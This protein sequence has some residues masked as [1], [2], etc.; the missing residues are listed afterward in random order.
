[1]RFTIAIAVFLAVV[2][3]VTA[4][5]TTDGCAAMSR[6]THDIPYENFVASFG[7]CADADFAEGD[8]C[9]M[10]CASGFKHNE[11]AFC[12]NG[13][14]TFPDSPC[15]ADSSGDSIYQLNTELTCEAGGDYEAQCLGNQ[16]RIALNGYSSRNAAA[17]SWDS[18]YGVVKN[19]NSPGA[20][21]TLS[22]S[23]F[24]DLDFVITLTVTSSIGETLSCD[25]SISI[26]DNEAPELYGIYSE[27]LSVEC[28]DLPSALAGTARDNCDKS[29]EVVFAEDEIVGTSR[30][31][32]NYVI[33]SWTATD[34]C[35]NQASQ[36]QTITVHDTTAPTLHG[37]GDDEFAECEAVPLACDVVAFDNCESDIEVSFNE[38]RQDGDCDSDYTLYR[39]WSAS[40]S[41][42]NSVSASQTVTVSDNTAPELVG[43]P[44]DMIVECT[45]VPAAANVE[46]SDNCGAASL[47]FEEDTTYDRDGVTYYITRTWTATD[48]CGNTAVASHVI[49][50]SDSTPPTITGVGDSVKT[51]PRDVPGVCTVDAIDDCG[52]VTCAYEETT[53][54]GSCL[55][56][57]V[58]TRTWTCTDEA[59]N[60]A[61]ES[62]VIEVFDNNWPTWTGTPP[63]VLTVECSAIPDFEL[64]ATDEEDGH[65]EVHFDFRIKKGDDQNQYTII[66]TWTAEDSCGHQIKF[67]QE[68]NVVDVT[69]PILVGI[70]PS[71][72][73]DCDAIPDCAE[74]YATDNCEETCDKLKVVNEKR[75]ESGTCDNQFDIIRTFSVSD[76]SGNT[77]S[78]EQTIFVTDSEAP[79]WKN[80]PSDI[81]GAE[82][83]Q[84]PKL[85]DPSAKDNCGEATISKSEIEIDG[86]CEHAY[87]LLRY[88]TA[89]DDCGNAAHASQTVEVHD[90]QAPTIQSDIP[91]DV[92]VQCPKIPENKGEFRV[93]DNCDANPQDSFTEEIVDSDPDDCMY[94]I[95]RTWSAWDDC[96]NTVG[97][98]QV[99]TVVDTEP[100]T[101]GRA[102]KSKTVESY[103]GYAETITAFDDCVGEVDVIFSEEEIDSRCDGESTFIRTWTASDGCN[104]D[105][106]TQTIYV[107]DKTPPECEA[108]DDD[109]AD[110]NSIPEAPTVWL[111]DDTGTQY[112]TTLTEKIKNR[113][114]DNTY[115]IIRTYSGEDCAGNR[116][117]CSYTIHVSD[118]EPPTIEAPEDLT[119]ECWSPDCET[120]YGYDDCDG[121]ITARMTQV[122]IDY[123]GKDDYD[124]TIIRTFTA[125]DSCDNSASDS[126]TIIIEDTEGPSLGP[127]PEDESAECDNVPSK[128]RVTAEDDCDFVKPTYEEEII[129]GTCEDE[130][131]IIR[132]WC[133]SDSSG[134]TECK[135]QTIDVSDT[136]PPEMEDACMEEIVYP[137][138][139]VQDAKNRKARD[140][141]D[142][143]PEVVFDETFSSS[144]DP[145]N[146]QIYR[147][148][149]AT[150]D[151]GNVFEQHQ[152]ATVV[153]D[154]PPRCPGVKD[155]KY[156][157]HE[158]IPPMESLNCDDDCGDVT[159]DMSELIIDG[160]C[161]DAHTRIRTWTV[162]DSSGNS[163][164]HTQTITVRD[165]TAP[166]IHG[167]VHTFLE[168]YEEEHQDLDEFMT[169]LD[170]TDNCA[171]VDLHCWDEETS[172]GQCTARKIKR[173]C[174]AT[175]NCGNTAKVKQEIHI[176]VES[177]YNYFEER[178]EAECDSIPDWPRGWPGT[179]T[180]TIGDYICTHG[181]TLTRRFVF[182]D[183]C[184]R[185]DEYVQIITVDDTT[186][187]TFSDIVD[188]LTVECDEK[189]KINDPKVTDN[190]DREVD[191][192][193]TET[194]SRDEGCEYTLTR[195]WKATDDCGNTASV[196]QIVKVVDT[197]PPTI[198]DYEDES[199][200]A[201]KMPKPVK[202]PN[203]DDNCCGPTC[204]YDEYVID[205][206]CEYEYKVVR[207]WT[208]EDDAEN[209][210]ISTRTISVY[211]DRAP[212]L[213]PKPKDRVI[214]GAKVLDTPYPVP[215]VIATDEVEGD[216]TDEIVYTQRQI[217]YVSRDDYMLIRTWY[218]EDD[219]GNSDEHEQ[220]IIVEPPPVDFPCPPCNEEAPC[221]DIPPPDFDTENIQ[222][223]LDEDPLHDGTELTFTEY[224]V[225]G[226][227]DHEWTIFRTWTITD[228]NGNSASH[229]QTIYVVDEQAPEWTTDPM[230]E[231]EEI[232]C[233]ELE[234]PEGLAALD[235]CDNSRGLSY[236][237]AIE[238]EDESGRGL[239]RII[240]TWTACDDC[241]NCITHRVTIRETDPTPPEFDLPLPED[242]SFECAHE[243]PPTVTGSDNCGD[244]TIRLKSKKFD[245]ECK[246]A[247]K[248][249][250]TWTITD[251]HGNS[252]SHE[253]VYTVY[254]NTP[255]TFDVDTP[256]ESACCSALAGCHG[257]TAS[258]NCGGDVR[259]SVTDAI[260]SD[261]GSCG[262]DYTIVRTYVATDRCGHT[263]TQSQNIFVMDC[264]FPTLPGVPEDVSVPCDDVPKMQ[265]IHAID[266]CDKVTASESEEIVAGTCEDQYTIYRTWTASDCVGNTVDGT[267]TIEV[268]DNEAPELKGLPNH[269]DTFLQVHCNGV[270]DANTVT[271]KDN[272]AEAFVAFNEE[273]I[274]ARGACTHDYTL[275]RSWS[276]SDDCGNTNSFIQTIEVSDDKAPSMSLDTK[277]QFANCNDIPD[278]QAAAAYDECD[279]ESEIEVD[280]DEEFISGTC[281]N[282]YDIVRTWTACDVCGNCNI[283]SRTIHVQDN[284]PPSFIDAPEA[285]SFECPDY[286][287]PQT[288]DATDDCDATV[289]IEFHEEDRKAYGNECLYY[290]VRTW[291]ATDNC[292]NSN[293]H[294]IWIPVEDTT[295]PWLTGVPDDSDT[296]ECVR[297]TK[298]KDQFD[299][300]GHDTCSET[301]LRSHVEKVDIECAD[302]YAMSYVWTVSDKCGNSIYAEHRAST[303][304]T[305]NPWFDQEFEDISAECHE[306]PDPETPTGGDACDPDPAITFRTHSIEVRGQCSHANDL[307]RTWT[308]TDR[309]DNS[310]EMTQTVH[311]TDTTAP[312]IY[313]VPDDFYG[314]C[315]GSVKDGRVYADDNCD[316]HVD[317]E[318]IEEV[319]YQSDCTFT[320]E[321]TYT[322]TDD[323]GNTAQD[324]FT[325]SYTDN[326]APVLSGAPTEDEL[327]YECG[328]CPGKIPVTAKD[329][330]VGKVDVIFTEYDIDTQDGDIRTFVRTW[331]ASDECGN[332]AE[333]TVTIHVGDHI[334]PVFKGEVYDDDAECGKIP[335]A[336]TRKFSDI[337]DEDPTI[338]YTEVRIDGSCEHEYTLVRTWTICDASGNCATD[339][340]TIEVTD[341]TGPRLSGVPGDKKGS[342][343]MVPYPPGVTAKDDC[344]EDEII[345][346]YS[347][348][349]IGSDRANNYQIVR[350]YTACDS[351]G[352]C[353]TES[354][355]ITVSD[356]K[357]PR[358]TGVPG[359]IRVEY[360]G[361][362]VPPTDVECT[363]ECD[364]VTCV[365]SEEIVDEWCEYGYTI[366]RTWT[367]CDTS[368]NC[369]SKSQTIRVVDTTPPQIIGVP[370]DVTLEHWNVPAGSTDGITA[371]D[372]TGDVLEVTSCGGRGDE[373]I[374]GT[375]DNNY[376][377]VRKF[378]AVDLCGNEAE[379]SY[380]IRVVDTTAPEFT[381]VVDDAEYECDS[382]PPPC[383]VETIDDDS[384]ISFSEK[385]IRGS[386][387]NEYKLIRKW[388][389]H[390]DCGN[391]NTLTQTVTVTDQTA[392][393]FTRYPGD[394]SVE[395]DCD[396]FPH[397]ATVQALDN[398]DNK[399]KVD[400]IE[401]KLSDRGASEDNYRIIRTW[402]A[403][404]DCGNAASWSQTVSVS[405]TT[406]PTLSA[407]PDDRTE[408]CDAITEPAISVAYDN[409]D[410]GVEAQFTETIIAGDCAS[411]FTSIRHWSATDRSGLSTEH[412][413][414]VYV[415]D[416]EAPAIA[417]GE[418]NRACLW[419]VDETYHVFARATNSL[420]YQIG[421]N[422]GAATY[423]LSGCQSNNDSGLSATGPSSAWTDDCYYD[424]LSDKVYIRASYNG[425]SSRTYSLSVT[426]TDE[427]GNV[428]DVDVTV[429]VPSSERD[430]LSQ[431]SECEAGF[432]LNHP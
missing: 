112:P 154:E 364:N 247:Y 318:K 149:T 423:A 136:T 49:T 431:E 212:K 176:M 386:C 346:T 78:A 18:P 59:G 341:T 175:D 283:Q 83:H 282:Q 418:G 106:V 193:L 196:F 182:T 55:W 148:W 410:D 382:V 34:S 333:A 275:I 354:Y 108:P 126:Q 102:P 142:K 166:E 366:I 267:Q 242:A 81:F 371:I 5:G 421:D 214:S 234:D 268:Y 33:R 10:Q 394:E 252:D 184:G 249:L 132:T 85:K 17:Y 77:A 200:Y 204:E 281:E 321:T 301:Q 71:I 194:Q 326:E 14:W 223:C 325:V 93:T 294:E 4:R 296:L 95:V 420:T 192:V 123:D 405:D 30:S 365:E 429:Y 46:A 289:D 360:P 120:V 188:G 432:T 203:W 291:T 388:V 290:V 332:T 416:D 292:G 300:E 233:G 45:D 245:A 124:Y 151:C 84:V 121:E 352:N 140:N 215:D 362:P 250:H 369:N 110:C 56:N 415:V 131:Q 101:L 426:A 277:K 254:D 276:T 44:D 169:T 35:G 201:L 351:C 344:H 12:E 22:D 211:D 113:D 272:C 177:E 163:A 380:T 295:D 237:T 412:T 89:T 70:P 428:A 221:D 103:D 31:P 160:S 258:D 331:T 219:C 293:T 137:C 374:P 284:T 15:V 138:D 349:I 264:E 43:V 263:A 308:I 173:F 259:V 38:F 319:T 383:I 265:K 3:G 314:E 356:D 16:V 312:T 76:C 399:V 65:L 260:V 53:S 186:P 229:T 256:D 417:E 47:E 230:P 266:D 52:T 130:W 246:D 411:E 61:T 255:P 168:I 170:A 7:A 183:K 80:V 226:E 143:T 303:A 139:K 187:P 8:G 315:G 317:I 209:V 280:L 311:V 381:D 425:G 225:D 115:D 297:L 88:W 97:A 6:D 375:C 72:D 385:R 231:N 271:A 343:N 348:E 28:D 68:I 335:K 367:S 379:E 73:A 60:S 92:T 342:C 422:C 144:R 152:T 274:E 24:C 361:I 239:R 328:D 36:S 357:A 305:L 116:G 75:Q 227:C 2:G 238:E 286:P 330:C 98:Q 25:A 122:F 430:A 99:I 104:S 408:S 134:N 404:D 58:L 64:F 191:F 86:T 363:D 9:W 167:L 395:C 327:W 224:T 114:C 198:G 373:I 304:D 69:D 128:G 195:T 20:V 146:Y 307:V 180:E 393:V 109:Y 107:A 413:A 372:S 347:E 135:S 378:C 119:L 353:N 329:A 419:P 161:L 67:V 407:T 387:K 244:A 172:G 402:S 181:Y 39:S 189:F 228:V 222:A 298:D 396:D 63:A 345:P 397:P 377:I 217:N 427:C 164:T 336:K 174:T 400:F 51:S 96:G 236:V 213:S 199:V 355:T 156:E 285:S 57:Y 21:L 185:V 145:N 141:C 66:R 243:D 279:F 165:Y 235:N 339:T 82:C 129:P 11:M 338:T 309:C 90:T 220:T 205:G 100:P 27:D 87:T 74:V 171:E 91:E 150:D 48:E 323:C 376:K 117:K 368:G 398:C 79:T 251:D 288:I 414:S 208:C 310:V 320:L 253:V 155:E 40:D 358:I 240:R 105:Y 401:F 278:P 270:P 32:N 133:V 94:Q 391:R 257:V 316:D 202:Q 207:T 269:G 403:A 41:T 162:T 322:A 287:G 210:V 147:K 324:S 197:T 62:Q 158:D 179:P 359:D 262:S 306:I 118:V 390:D 334:P 406:A 216:L 50:V 389:A 1:M 350:T 111:T 302:T 218:V 273:R 190:C 26:S 159:E 424:E 299:V 125:T 153:D 241:G 409:C 370:E 178:D 248:I 232:L 261:R 337:C 127:I 19:G 384:T 42:G 340:Q 206:S 23:E 313:N 54:D 37:V 29:V 392:P 157:C 13:E